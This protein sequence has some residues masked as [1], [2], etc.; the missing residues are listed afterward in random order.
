MRRGPAATTTCPLLAVLALSAC[1]SADGDAEAAISL[2][3]LGPAVTVSPDASGVPFVDQA[4]LRAALLDIGDLPAGFSPVPNLEDL[5]LQRGPET[6]DPG[7]A[8]AASTD[9]AQCGAILSP[10]ADQ[11]AGAVVSA[12]SSFAGPGFTTI[13]QDAASYGTG[14]D[15]A[16]AFAEVQHSLDHC[17][18][19]SGTDADGVQ[20]Q[21]RIGARDQEPVGDASAAF[22]LVTTSAGLDLVSDVVVVVVGGTVSQLVAT[23]QDPID[24]GVFDGLTRTVVN[25]LVPAPAG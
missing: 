14:A 10:V 13:D 11:R 1:S 23:G 7:T 21:Y 6:T 5:G 12:S 24:A 16:E 19:Y 17:A 18:E 8:P 3:P 9:P 2:A 20:V 4:T 25:K 15:A 22:R